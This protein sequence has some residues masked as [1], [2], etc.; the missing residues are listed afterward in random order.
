M[1]DGS[2]EIDNVKLQ[3]L[4]DLD[5]LQ[6]FQ[7]DF[8]ESMEIASITVDMDG[9]PITKPT[10][11]T[12]FCAAL[13]QSSDEGRR[14]CA[15][16]HLKGGMEATRTGKPYIYTCH[17]GLV[18]F[19]APIT[20]AGKHI[21]TILGGQVTFSK[22][23]E[24]KVIKTANELGVNED[25]Y[26]KAAND[27]HI[28][29]ESRVRASASILFTVANTLCQIGYEQLKIKHMTGVLSDNFAQIS[30]AMEEIA[31]SSVEVT[32]NQEHLNKEIL[33]IKDISDEINNVLGYIKSI[34]DQTK[35]LGLNAA[36]EAAR[37]GEAGK[38]FGVV[39]TEIRKLSQNSKETANKI[40]T[41][42]K[43]IQNSVNTTLQAADDTLNTTQQQSAAIQET[44]ASVEEVMSLSEELSSFANKK[45]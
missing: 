33:N 12:N 18:D 24:N 25:A 39:A 42:T 30:A 20:I 11:Y 16:S 40:S 43:N 6:K 1:S 37:A 9:K 3:D 17:A 8:G 44:N 14:R 38:G 21:A 36:I 41:L 35:M 31:A 19:A 22:P 15:E 4:I 34:A 27:I 13:T 7:D 45:L 23:D 5:F 26:K 2:F 32:H 10:R 28:E 29:A